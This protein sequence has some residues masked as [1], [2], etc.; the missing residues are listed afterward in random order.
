[1]KKGRRRKAEVEKAEGR[2]F[3]VILRQPEPPFA[4]DQFAL[5]GVAA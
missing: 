2:S 5:R 4:I 1:M 3:R